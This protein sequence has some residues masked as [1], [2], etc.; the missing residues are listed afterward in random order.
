MIRVP[1]SYRSFACFLFLTF[2]TR[3]CDIITSIRGAFVYILS[4]SSASYQRLNQLAVSSM[5]PS[6][7][8]LMNFQEIQWI[9]FLNLTKK[10]ILIIYK[11]ILKVSI[12]KSCFS[13]RFQNY[14]LKYY[15][16]NSIPNVSNVYKNS[17]K[18]EARKY[19]GISW[20]SN[21]Q[22][23]CEINCDLVQWNNVYLWNDS[24]VLH[25]HKSWPQ[26]FPNLTV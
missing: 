2:S 15:H 21:Q 18:H 22:L 24:Y 23:A 13:S 4:V 5:F 17:Q 11:K 8:F 1:R 7:Q 3:I 16:D 9:F 14:P 6:W 10:T 19:V 12:Y 25:L 20:N 26:N